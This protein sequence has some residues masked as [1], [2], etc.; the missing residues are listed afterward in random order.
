MN[1]IATVIAT[2]KP[3]DA[4]SL[5]DACGVSGLDVIGLCFMAES[6]AADVKSFINDGLKDA[7]NQWMLIL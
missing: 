2:N 7:R 4:N 1:L 3:N 5:K 6:P